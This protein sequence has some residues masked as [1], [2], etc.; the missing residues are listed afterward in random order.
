M[1]TVY[2]NRTGCNLPS[3]ASRLLLD[4]ILVT[5]CLAGCG[6][7]HRTAADLHA[8]AHDFVW[9]GK[10]NGASVDHDPSRRIRDDFSGNTAQYPAEAAK[11][12][13]KN[14]AVMSRMVWV[15]YHAGGADLSLVRARPAIRAD[16]R[17][18]RPGRGRSDG[19][20]R[21]KSLAPS[22]THPLSN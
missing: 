1:S 15:R 20:L 7:F 5:P 22:V 13:I 3:A 9:G 10:G 4:C 8:D 16:P 21:L 18:S 6:G 14:M 11:I 12:C 19:L 2:T 17:Q